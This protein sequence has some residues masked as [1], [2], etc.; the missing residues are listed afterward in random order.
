MFGFRRC[1]H[2]FR[3]YQVPASDV[4]RNPNLFL[5]KGRL[6]C[7]AI[8]ADFKPT[9]KPPTSYH[10]MGKTRHGPFR[11]PAVIEAVSTKRRARCV[12][13]QFGVEAALRRHLAM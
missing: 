13:G 4:R 10:A 6:G 8:L 11:W 3:A 9:T 5:E 7:A 12:V 2:Y 1:G